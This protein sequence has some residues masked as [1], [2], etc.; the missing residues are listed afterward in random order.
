MKGQSSTSARTKVAEETK[1]GK[2]AADR[3]GV[4]IV[5]SHPITRIGL[6]QLINNQLDLVVYDEAGTAAQALNALDTSKPNLV[7]SEIA[8]PDKSGLEL[9]K[10]IEAIRPGLPVLVISMRDEA[11]YAERALR[12]GARGYITKDE[13]ATELMNA[14][15]QVL[16]GKI[17][18]SQRIST[19]ILES[20]LAGDPRRVRSSIA[21]LSDREFEVLELIGRAL[22]TRD[23][24]KRLHL[25]VKTVQAHRVNVKRKLRLKTSAELIRYAARW[26]DHERLNFS[27]ASARSKK[28]YEYN[29]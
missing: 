27:N 11:F 14:I 4:L 23:I 17:Y 5:N 16:E 26:I 9:I 15:R 29:A 22:S 19:Q 3:T 10:D 1:S 8:L 12:A 6:A 21:G 28:S 20:S 2:G 18:L 13:S 24:A 7:L 25:S